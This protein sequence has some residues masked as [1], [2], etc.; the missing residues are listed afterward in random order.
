CTLA[1]YS[2]IEEDINGNPLWTTYYTAEDVL[3]YVSY[4]ERDANGNVV[5]GNT[6]STNSG[7]DGNFGTFDDF[8]Y[9][10]W[11][12]YNSNGEV[13]ATGTERI[14]TDG[15]WNTE[16]DTSSVDYIYLLENDINSLALNAGSSG[17]IC[18]TLPT[19]LGASGDINLQVRDQN[20]APLSGVIAQLGANG[21]TVTTDA[22]G[23][24]S[25]VGLSG[26]Q[27][28]HLFKDGYAWE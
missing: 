25:F 18:A 27:D 11:Y 6:Y 8:T 23:E 13:V 5:L 2:V 19:S 14:G 26:T 17:D 3:S 12:T 10:S 15:I 7:P 4:T 9:F 22:N 1:S 21:S 16:D 28:V 20:A 24:A